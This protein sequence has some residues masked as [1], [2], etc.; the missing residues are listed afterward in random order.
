L[1][2]SLYS[3]LNDLALL[4]KEHLDEDKHNLPVDNDRLPVVSRWP[5]AIVEEAVFFLDFLLLKVLPAAAN[6]KQAESWNA[7]T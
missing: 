1:R 2:V 6:D 4:L 7:N 5:V 3:Y